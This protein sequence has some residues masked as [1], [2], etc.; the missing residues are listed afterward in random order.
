MIELQGGHVFRSWSVHDAF[1]KLHRERERLS[2][3]EAANDLW[4]QVDA[5]TNSSITAWHMTDL[6]WLRHQDNVREHLGVE[7][8][9]GLQDEVR[10]QCPELAICDVIANAA[11]HGGRALA[12]DDRPNVETIIRAVPVESNAEDARAELGQAP[13]WSLRIEVDGR[14]SD[15]R[16]ALLRVSQYWGEFIQRHCARR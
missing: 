12:R 5:V 9:R 15:P 3:A 1:R 2:A 7:C 16:V 10:H 8:L 13:Q 11:K 14:R 6:V 4:G